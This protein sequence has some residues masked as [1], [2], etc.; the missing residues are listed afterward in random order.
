MNVAA[1]ADEQ[2]HR[3]IFLVVLVATLIDR[4]YLLITFGTTH[5]G[6]DDVIFWNVANDMAQG[7]FREPFLYGQNYNPA[8]ESLLA[9]PLL[10]SGAPAYIALPISTSLLALLPFL[11]FALW[12]FRRKE[13]AAAT[14]FAAMPLLLPIEW[15]ILTMITR[16]FVTGLAVLSL[17]P[18]LLELR[19]AT[20]RSFLIGATLYTALIANQN[21][22]LL[23]APFALWYAWRP[24]TL[25]RDRLALVA[26]AMP[27]LLLHVF[28]MRFYSNDPDRIVHRLDD[29]RLTFHPGELIPEAL[30]QLQLHF[31][32][33]T[34]LCPSCGHLVLVLIFAVC[35]RLWLRGQRQA[36][37]ALSV[38][39][40]IILLALAFPKLHDGFVGVFF[41]FSRMFLAL[42]LV[43]A[44]GLS[45]GLLKS[46]TTR[47]LIYA[48]A[49]LAPAALTLKVLGTS[50][51]IAKEMSQQELLPVREVELSD[52]R[53]DLARLHSEALH[54]KADLIVALDGDGKYRSQLI[55]YGAPV[56]EPTLPATLLAGTDRRKWRR[57]EERSRIS[58]TIL[59][60]G[61]EE[62]RWNILMEDHRGLQRIGAPED[63]MHLFTE[64]RMST[65]EILD[66]LA[67]KI[68]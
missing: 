37:L 32:W 68:D 45:L 54:Y 11:S 14:L 24:G 59:F 16:G 23:A 9:V 61:G 4:L 42:P 5:T 13:F 63:R 34:P 26:G 28:A 46:S 21:A 58:S 38:V 25:L 3:L 1:S 56:L 52:F 19:N 60:V 8:L 22:L 57:D 50:A 62:E 43:L 44:F 41:P 15:G 12:H 35:L 67:R 53:V 33:L 30:G 55:A 31:A 2:R 27:A 40:P 48:L 7:I 65:P 18:W 17:L 20:A 51:V 10:W 39:F 29:W 36:A 6:T 66:L 49:I 64:N 47:W